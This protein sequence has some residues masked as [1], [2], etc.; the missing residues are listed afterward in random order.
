MNIY[1]ADCL[2]ILIADIKTR[3]IAT[4][5]SRLK[6]LKKQIISKTLKKLEAIGSRK[7]NLIISLGPSI[8]GD[9]YQVKK[10]D[11]EDLIIQI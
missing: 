6:G 2:L 8:K 4:Y 9:K 3:N 1:T 7:N 5:H 11:I 10:K